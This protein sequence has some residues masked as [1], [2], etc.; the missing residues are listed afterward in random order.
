MRDK[1]FELD[2]D[3]VMQNILKAP[4]TLDY[5]KK[6]AR[7]FATQCGEGYGY[8]AYNEGRARCNASVSTDSYEA[9][10][11]NLKNNTLLKVTGC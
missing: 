10:Q 8:S 5:L 1:I 7:D 3:G 2:K 11:D 9:I 4:G 6:M